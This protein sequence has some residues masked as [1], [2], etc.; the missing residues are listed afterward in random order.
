MRN[1]PEL[2]QATEYPNVQAFAHVPRNGET[3]QTDDAFRMLVFGGSFDSFDDHPRIHKDITTHEVVADWR[4]YPRPTSSAAGAY[5]ITESTWDDFTGKFGPMS[6]TPENQTLCAVWL[7]DRAGAL[8]DV[9]A[10]RLD[11]AIRKLTKVWTSLGLAKRQAQAPAIF[12]QY[13][14]SPADL[15]DSSLPQPEVAPLILNPIAQVK[16][17]GIFAA[18]LPTIIQLI[19]Q[20][21]S[22]FKPGS[23]VAQRNVAAATIV[24][25]AISDATQAVNLQDAVE[26]MQSDPQALAAAQKA[27]NDVWPSLVDSG[28]AVTEAR[29]AA[30]SADQTPPWK[31]PAV[32]ITFLFVPL[33]YGAAWAVLYRDGAS[34]DLKTMVVTAIFAGLLGSITGFFLG[35]SLGSQRKDAL[36]AK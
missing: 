20:L 31:N 34:D 30:S 8:E 17:M 11:A 24:T 15:P 18:L 2:V 5:Q 16:P 13:G 28:P 3:N 33:I 10:G 27:I 7:M 9:I 1:L 4:N 6:F 36:A 26:K 32:W 21:A 29:K 23:E 12:A 14:G 19:P 22:V 25:Q 35:S